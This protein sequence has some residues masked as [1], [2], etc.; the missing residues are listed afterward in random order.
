MSMTVLVVAWCE[1]IKT[2]YSGRQIESA[3]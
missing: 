2:H 3:M 1:N